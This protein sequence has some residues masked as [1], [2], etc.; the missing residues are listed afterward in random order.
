MAEDC[1]PQHEVPCLHARAPMRVVGV[2]GEGE[3]TARLHGNRAGLLA[4]RE[5][6]ARALT[7]E[8]DGR[9]GRPPRGGRAALRPVGHAGLLARPGGAAQGAGEARLLEVL[10]TDVGV[11]TS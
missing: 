8:G 11:I 6:V 1:R 10:D 7:A 4:L 9:R 3:P 5:Q 2:G